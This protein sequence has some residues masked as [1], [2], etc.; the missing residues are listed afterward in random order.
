MKLKYKKLFVT[1]HK[2]MVGSAFVRILKK[3]KKFKIIVADRKK[4]DLENQ[5]KVDLF[6]KKNKPDMV[7]NAAALAGGIYANETF[8]ADFID[9]NLI[10]QHNVIKS[11]YKYKI[12]KLLF[13]GSSCI[14]PRNCSQPMHE[15]YLLGN[16]LEKT[17]EAYAV[18]KIAGLK[19]CEFFN[20]QF[21]TDFRSVMPTN[22]YGLNDKYHEKNS[23]VIPAMIM[24]FHKAKSQNKKFVKVWGTGKAKREFIY[25]DDM[26][27][28]C[29]KIFLKP[30]EKYYKFLK[31]KK[32]SFLNIGSGQEL[33]IK[34]LSKIIKKITKFDGKIIFDK[35]K[36]DGTPRKLLDN[37]S[38][39]SFLKEKRNFV[40]L[41]N[42]LSKTYDDFLK[43]NKKK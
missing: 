35:T 40:K 17:N 23:H 5:K 22:I 7:I 18:A 26:V 27:K 33:S 19:M 30:K 3:K 29:L 38:L 21:S 43:K 16:Y 37:S 12:E 8:S 13:L 11:C 36:K 39:N 31:R 28:L 2:G 6:F 32:I 9:K 14:Y 20:K 1:G 25:V 34:K 24:K 41:E 10:I 4:L 15:K 42:G